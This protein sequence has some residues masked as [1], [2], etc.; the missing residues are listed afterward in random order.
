MTGGW[1]E[2]SC[3]NHRANP[4]PIK[5]Y[6]AENVEIF[7][8]RRIWYEINKE[9]LPAAREPIV[10]RTRNTSEITEGNTVKTRGN[11]STN[12]GEAIMPKIRSGSGKDFVTKNEENR[13]AYRT[14]WIWDQESE[15][16]ETS[17]V[18]SVLWNTD[19]QDFKS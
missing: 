19:G 13:S 4:G 10:N 17:L 18:P 1:S 11:G 3:K 2:I 5:R 14:F 7:K 15:K 16:L 8:T 12:I 6:R 9:R